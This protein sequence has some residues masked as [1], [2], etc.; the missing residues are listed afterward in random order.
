MSVRRTIS[1]F[2]QYLKNLLKGETDL[3]GS[4]RAM[5][6]RPW[7][8]WPPLVMQI[9]DSIAEYRCLPG[10]VKSRLTKTSGTVI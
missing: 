6:S 10:Y 5:L 1:I 2:F 4:T 3:E 9:H 8:A 7:I